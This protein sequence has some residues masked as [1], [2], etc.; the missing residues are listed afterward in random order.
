M[1]ISA[2]ALAHAQYGIELIGPPFLLWASATSEWFP[3]RS[4][5]QASLPSRFG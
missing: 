1:P 5:W 4:R 2:N 3:E